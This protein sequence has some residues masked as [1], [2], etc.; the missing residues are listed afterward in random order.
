MENHGRQRIKK[1]KQSSFIEEGL[2]G[3]VQKENHETLGAAEPQPNAKE[4]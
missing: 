1:A 2:T 3:S 4:F